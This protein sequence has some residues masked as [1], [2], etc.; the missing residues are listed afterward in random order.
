MMASNFG[1]RAIW[2]FASFALGLVGSLLAVHAIAY[3]FAA[4]LP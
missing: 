2:L 3:P 1:F 4:F